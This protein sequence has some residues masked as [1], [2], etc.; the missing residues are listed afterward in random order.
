[1]R[2]IVAEAVAI[3]QE[4]VCEALPV[5][6]VGMNKELM[7]EYI[8]FVADH[9]LVSL[10]YDK[11]Y[12]VMC[13]FDWMELISLQVRGLRLTCKMS[14]LTDKNAFC[15]GRTNFFERRVG[16]YQRA[17]VMSALSTNNTGFKFTLDEDF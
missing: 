4:F 11:M 2:D 13:P 15:K 6:L 10:G 17:G 3:E 8:S 14:I 12:N 1:M 9:L 7:A 5:S 16:E